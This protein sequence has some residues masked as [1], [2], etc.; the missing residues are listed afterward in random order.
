MFSI[1]DRLLNAPKFYRRRMY[2][3]LPIGGYSRSR[4]GNRRLRSILPGS[5]PIRSNRSYRTVFYPPS[6]F[7]GRLSRFLKTGQVNS[8]PTDDLL[9]TCRRYDLMPVYVPLRRPYRPCQVIRMAKRAGELFI[10]EKVRSAYRRWLDKRIAPYL[11]LRLG[12]PLGQ[13]QQQQQRRLEG[14]A[15]QRNGLL[16]RKESEL[17]S[18]QEGLDQQY[19]GYIQRQ[20]SALDGADRQREKLV[21]EYESFQRQRSASEFARRQQEESSQQNSESLQRQRINSALASY[22][23]DYSQQQK[24]IYQDRV[25]SVQNQRR[26]SVFM[27]DV[28]SMVTPPIPPAALC[29]VATV[30]LWS[31][32]NNT[33][34]F[35]LPIIRHPAKYGRKKIARKRACAL[36]R[37]PSPPDYH[38]PDLYPGTTDDKS[39]CKLIQVQI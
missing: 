21:E 25:K 39:E 34:I 13:Y 35:P 10:R 27:A 17:A 3:G 15:Q 11:G 36:I 32:R 1:K 5:P 6:Y 9:A 28:S 18:Q 8:Q 33:P 24:D 37:T 31:D 4:F 14:S 2:G 12:T 29:G 30:D 7:A 22:Q 19:K 26:R 16:Q 20:R 23:E 38:L